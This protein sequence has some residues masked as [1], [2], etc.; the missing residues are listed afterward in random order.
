[1]RKLNL[2][3]FNLEPNELLEREQLKSVVGGD[4]FDCAVMYEICDI[5]IGY[6]DFNDCMVR[7]GC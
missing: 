6:N 7:W 2:K 1:M 4:G 3:N 5:Y